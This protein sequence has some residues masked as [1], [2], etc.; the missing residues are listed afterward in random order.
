MVA[1]ASGYAAS[2]ADPYTTAPPDQM[3]A[4][5]QIID[6]EFREMVQRKASLAG[7]K[8]PPWYDMDPRMQDDEVMAEANT[9]KQVHSMRLLQS[10]FMELR[11]GMEVSAT[12]ERDEDWVDM[13][14]TERFI[15][16]L[17]RAEHNA[18][19]AFIESMTLQFTSRARATVEREETAM[20]EGYLYEWWDDWETR[21]LLSGMGSLRRALAYDML[22]HAMLA[23]FMKPDPGNERVGVMSRRVDPKCVFPVFEGDRGLSRVYCIYEADYP[24]VLGNFGDGP[25]GTATRKIKKLATHTDNRQGMRGPDQTHSGEVIYFANRR[26]EF[27]FWKGQ[28]IRKREHKYWRV[29]WIIIPCCWRQPSGTAQSTGVLGAN[30]LPGNMRD[31]DGRILGGTSVQRDTARM[32]AP[33]LE[34][35][36]PINDEL[37]MMASRLFTGIRDA[38]DPPVV[39]QRDL[40]DMRRGDLEVKN[41]SGGVTTV[42]G[43]T[44]ITPY[45]TIPVAENM[46]PMLEIFKTVL[47]AGIPAPV[48]QGQTL[49]AQSSGQAID[50]LNELGFQAW[51][52]FTKMYQLA[53]AQCGHAALSTV[54]DW[55]EGLP[56]M[57]GTG[58]GL[59][60]PRRSP[61]DYGD[62]S[63]YRLTKQ[64]LEQSGCYVES[65]LTRFSLSGMVGAANVATTLNN[66]GIG[67]DRMY[68]ELLGIPGVPEELIARRRL[69]NMENSPDYANPVM[70][71]QLAEQIEMA[72]ARNDT[73]T[74]HSLIP[75]FK[76]IV[77]IQTAKDQQLQMMVGQMQQNAMMN[78]IETQQAMQGNGGAGPGG[79]NP[80]V[81]LQPGDMGNA[82]G[83][84]GGRL[85]NTAAGA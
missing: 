49:G 22:M 38:K 11:V 52:P 41:W 37:E 62:Y 10:T 66:L 17:I 45:P 47:Q 44:Q 77:A 20:K 25:G 74:L 21:T 68:I 34:S 64:I 24:T 39:E 60:V 35:R 18:I 80:A 31:Q 71:N 75:L 48:L 46:T 4:P 55:N 65:R 51:V 63:P 78:E 82:V 69:Q 33:Y 42:Q 28:L 81:A 9:Q 14:E 3:G 2:A 79:F 54:R 6:A 32:Y 7:P 53:T 13:G 67:D 40:A 85:P 8:P 57:D 43:T 26:E 61:G 58:T 72:T 83:G 23:V 12:F 27:I 70:I 36:V 50:I 76:R 15:V 29:P 84:E 1:Q 73:K 16:P 59:S 19:L 5:S 30:G 56:G